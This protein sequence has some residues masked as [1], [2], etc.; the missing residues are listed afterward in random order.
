MTDV[1][2]VVKRDFVGTKRNRRLRKA[3]MIP[4]ILYGHGKENISLSVPEQDVNAAIRHGSHFVSLGGDLSEDALIKEVQWNAFGTDVLHLDLTRVDRSESVDVTVTL[5][6]RGEAPGT[7]QG[8]VVQH[9]L[10]SVDIRCPVISLP[11]KLEVAINSL[12][13]N[14]TISAGEV[15]LPEGATLITAADALVVQCVEPT[16]VEET[17]AD[18][19]APS[20]PEVIGAKP[21][22]E[23]E[24]DD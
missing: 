11:D 10:H 9:Q 14:G 8:G 21:T 15:E 2:N 12:E 1:L 22:D 23:E 24:S 4:A 18:G 17:E 5:E 6:L 16:I 13:L 3:G 19:A 20:E 7:N